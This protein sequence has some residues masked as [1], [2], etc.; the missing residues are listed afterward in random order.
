MVYA[1]PPFGG[2]QQ[3]LEYLGRC[4]HRVAISNQRLLAAENGQVSFQWKDQSNNSKVMTL[5]VDE[6]IRR[7]LLHVHCLAP[8][9]VCNHFPAST[10]SSCVSNLHPLERKPISSLNLRPIH[11]IQYP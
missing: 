2:P 4:T 6:F 1:K 8:R 10:N 5:E 9:L 11:G 3:V 7:F